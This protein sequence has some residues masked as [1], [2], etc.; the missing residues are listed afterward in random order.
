MIGKPP[1]S[2]PQS[3]VNKINEWQ[4]KKNAA[5][6]VKKAE[7]RPGKQSGGWKCGVAEATAPMRWNNEV[8]CMSLNSKDCTW[9]KTVAECDNYLKTNPQNVKPLA[10]GKGHAAAW[11]GPGYDNKDHWCAK[12]SE[13]LGHPERIKEYAAKAPPPPTTVAFYSD[14]DFKGQSKAFGKG[15]YRWIVDAGFPNDALSSFIMP[16][17]SSLTLYEHADFKGQKITF[18]AGPNGMKFPCLINARIP[19]GTWND[20]VSSF[21]VA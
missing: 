3:L 15:R 14:C 7:E 18:G 11:G 4:A 1:S 19:G 17:N 8:E 21:E 5:A 10:C 13:A 12:V 20:K 16:P 6:N 2:P 9:A